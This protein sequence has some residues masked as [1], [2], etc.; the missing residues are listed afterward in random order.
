ME[1]TFEDIDLT[2]LCG[3]GFTWTGGEQKFMQ[4]LLEE[5][6]FDKTDPETGDTIYGSVVTPKRCPV[7]RRKKKEQYK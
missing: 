3:A 1:K 7:C 6:K 5:G 4:D 2:C